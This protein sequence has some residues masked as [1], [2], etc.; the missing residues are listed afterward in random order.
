MLNRILVSTLWLLFIGNTRNCEGFHQFGP[1]LSN[2][3]I[4]PGINTYDM[5]YINFQSRIY[6]SQLSVDEHN[7]AIHDENVV[8]NSLLHDEV[9]NNDRDWNSSMRV[10]YVAR[11]MYDGTSFHGWQDQLKKKR[12]VQGVL[13]N[14]FSKRLNCVTKVTGASR[15]DMGVHSKGQTI[16]FLA[17]P[18]LD[19]SHFEYSMNRML[20]DDIKIFNVS[21]APFK[22]FHAT[23]SAKGK[24][25]SYRFC[26]NS[27]VDPCLRRY[28][29]HVWMKTDMQIFERCLSHFIGTHNFKA[30]ANN[31]DELTKAFANNL[32][33][34]NTIRTIHSII[35]IKEE[36]SGYYRIEFKIQSALYKMIR[37]IVG[38]C[39]HVANGSM[40]ELDL[41][42]LLND[43][44]YSRHDNKAMPA[45]PEGLTLE[46][47][48]YDDY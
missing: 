25:Y 20:P 7:N 10:R 40:K 1:T 48:Y 44:S 30:F 45:P 29:A 17:D 32:I 23:G 2:E 38:T 34:F 47:V 35:L 24:M 6:N 12:T 42:K 46:H 9:N 26:T 21:L 33:E 22:A 31:V 18:T 43:N 16:H 19:Y 4:I 41:I 28:Y 37:C 13:N 36:M 3:Y 8:N 27:Y 5:R 39:F 15:T 14:N 11:V